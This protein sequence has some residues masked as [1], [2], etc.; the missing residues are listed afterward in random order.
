MQRAQS[1][2][3]SFMLTA[4][5][6]AECVCVAATS[7]ATGGAMPVRLEPA[8]VPM[9]LLRWSLQYLPLSWTDKLT[10]FL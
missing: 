8:T 1:L 5:A 3:D 2:H 9:Q 10:T 4:A 7:A 6:V